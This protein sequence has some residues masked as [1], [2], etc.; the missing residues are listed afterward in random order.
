MILIWLVAGGRVLLTMGTA[1]ATASVPSVRRQER[2]VV[3][4]ALL[5]GI[6]R[7]MDVLVDESRVLLLMCCYGPFVFVLNDDT[8]G[9]VAGEFCSV[10]NPTIAFL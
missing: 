8:V 5:R 10:G 3:A 1:G 6:R 7:T 2:S 9:S 4:I